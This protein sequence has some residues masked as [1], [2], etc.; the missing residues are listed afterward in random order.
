MGWLFRILVPA[1]VILF[2]GVGIP[3]IC[4]PGE[5]NGES[6]TR[7]ETSISDIQ[8]FD[9]RI[10][11]ENDLVYRSAA[12]DLIPGR[13]GNELATCSRN[14]KV[15]VTYG[16]RLSWKS[17]VAH[18]SIIQGTPGERAQVYSMDA[19][20]VIPEHE[21]DELLAVDEDFSVNLISYT[22]ASGW[23]TEIIWRDYDWLYEVDIGE[24][25]GTPDQKEIVVVGEFKRATILERDGQGW[26][27]TTIARDSEIIEACWISDILPERPG[28]EVL[29]GGGRGTLMVSYRE[30]GEWKVKDIMNFGDRNQISDLLMADIDPNIPGEEIYASTF[31]GNVRQVIRNGENWTQKVIHSEGRI[32]YGMETGEIAGHN[33]LTIGTYAYRTGIIWYDEGFNFKPLY[34]EEYLI[35]GTGIFDIDPAYEGSEILSLSYLGRVVMIYGDS[36]GAEIILPFHRTAV[37]PGETARI[38]FII[39]SRGGYDGDVQLSLENDISDAFDVQLGSPTTSSDSITFVEITGKQDGTTTTGKFTIIA[40]TSHGTSRQELAVDVSAFSGDFELSTA[41]IKDEMSADRQI[42]IG[43][44]VGSDKGLESDLI[45][46]TDHVPTGIS[47]S[48]QDPVMEISQGMSDQR[49]TLSSQGWVSPDTYLFFLIAEEE[50]TYARAAGVELDVKIRTQAEFRLALDPARIS[51]PRFSNTTVTLNMISLNGYTGNITLTVIGQYDG[52]KIDL[53]SSAVSVPSTLSIEIGIQDLQESMVIGIRGRGGELDRDAYMLLEVEPPRKDLIVKGPNST[54]ILEKLD[55]D[56]VSGNFRVYLEPVNGEIEDIVVRV[57]NLPANFSLTVLPSDLDRLFYPLNVTF[58]LEGP[59]D[60]L[61]SDLR[62]NFTSAALGGWEVLVPIA[63]EEIPDENGKNGTFPWWIVL[64]ISV[65]VSAAVVLLF[66]LRSRESND[67]NEGEGVRVEHEGHRLPDRS[68]AP[69]RSH[70][71]IGSDSRSH[72]RERHD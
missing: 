24:L 29:L 11:Q 58:T 70:R 31:D 18:I 61:P 41:E 4:L 67:L 54:V 1:F 2:F 26:E 51:A 33:V 22:E 8:F 21:G 68:P 39:E 55:N 48:F 59:L 16:S 30:S 32:I 40:K 9:Q 7:A 17:E 53:P 15:V 27:A 43:L 36:P 71:S 57:K 35:M 64:V 20:D 72:H 52:V 12:A 46:T 56:L 69:E 60:D 45:F 28:N 47:V 62:I 10:Y 34:S 13:E 66:F 42:N 38:P 19:G 65:L 5:S 23:K 63:V 14:G 49:V 50:G 6:G 44:Q 37:A 3:A 25:T